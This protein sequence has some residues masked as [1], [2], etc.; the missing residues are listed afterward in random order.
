MK[1]LIWLTVTKGATNARQ[2][3]IFNY[4]A[5]HCFFDNYDELSELLEQ[6]I[7]YGSVAILPQVTIEC[8]VGTGVRMTL[9]THVPHYQIPGLVEKIKA[10]VNQN[11]HPR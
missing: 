9:S 11:E 3:V 10:W 2:E 1:E 5:V 6:H 8:L 4:D 7:D